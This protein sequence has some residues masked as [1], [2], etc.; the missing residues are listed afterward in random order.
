MTLE[1]TPSEYENLTKK[2][3]DSKKRRTSNRLTTPTEIENEIVRMV[4][5]RESNMY[6]R[7]NL[8]TSDETINRIKKENGLWGA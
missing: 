6:I 7:R 8:H 1:L 4:K 3:A 5:A 2:V